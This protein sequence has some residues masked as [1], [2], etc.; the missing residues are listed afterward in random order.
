MGREEAAPAAGSRAT[1][2]SGGR[3]GEPAAAMSSSVACWLTGSC[4][5]LPLPP[6]EACTVAARASAAASASLQRDRDVTLLK[7]STVALGPARAL[8]LAQ[9]GA[10]A[11]LSLVLCESQKLGRL[12]DSP[13]DAPA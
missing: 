2:R 3:G 13:L 6:E 10:S 11:E 1:C 7:E 8:L 5:L 9:K 12:K 4:R